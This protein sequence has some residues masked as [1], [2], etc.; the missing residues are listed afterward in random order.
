MWAAAPLPPLATAGLEASFTIS[1][2]INVNIVSAGCPD[3][4]NSLK[5]P[6]PVVLWL[7]IKSP[8]CQVL[9]TCCLPARQSVHPASLLVD[10]AGSGKELKPRRWSA[11]GSPSPQLSSSQSLAATS[12]YRKFQTQIPARPSK[13]PHCSKEDGIDTSGSGGKDLRIEQVT[14]RNEGSS[15][16]LDPVVGLQRV[17]SRWD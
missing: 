4:S 8:F 16:S 17:H 11:K 10:R 14:R 9:P 7:N 2:S 6:W 12:D 13:R 15:S 3:Q 1:P 5:G